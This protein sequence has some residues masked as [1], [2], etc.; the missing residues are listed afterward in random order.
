MGR[1]VA[2]RR[3]SKQLGLVSY[4]KGT[5]FSRNHA[6]SGT[7]EHWRKYNQIHSPIGLCRIGL[8]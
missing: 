3:G 4:S 7:S 2:S 8:D 1:N 6:V 5:T